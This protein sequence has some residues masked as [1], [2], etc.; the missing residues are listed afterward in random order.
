M[1]MHELHDGVNSDIDF[2]HIDFMNVIVH[3]DARVRVRVHVCI[4]TSCTME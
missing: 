3:V 4:C 2:I 1:H